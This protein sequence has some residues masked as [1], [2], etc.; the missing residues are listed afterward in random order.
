MDLRSSPVR[1]TPTPTALSSQS[2]PPASSGTIV[3]G[4][5]QSKRSLI[6]S[7][8][9][10]SAIITIIELIVMVA[11]EPLFGNDHLT[12]AFVDSGTLIL[13]CLPCIYFLLVKPMVNHLFA[14]AKVEQ[15]LREMELTNEFLRQDS[16]ARTQAEL[17]ERTKA[18][19]HIQF[20]AGLLAVVR[21]AV[22]ATGKGGVILY[23][24]LFAES[25]F[26]WTRDEVREET[27]AKITGFTAEA[28]RTGLSG[29]GSGKG[30]SGEVN[31]IRKDG[32]HFPAFMT[33]STIWRKDG[34]A[35][36]FVYTFVDVTDRKKTEAAIRASEEK[37]S[38]VVENSPI[39]IF[40]Y[41]KGLLTFGNQR[42]F[43]M[44]GRTPADLPGLTLEAIIHPDDLDMVSDLWRKRLAGIGALQ[45]YECRIIT[46]NANTRW[47]TGRTALINFDGV[48]A[49]LGN[50]Q[51]STEK[52]KAETALRESRETLHRLSARLLTAQ[53]SER[54]RVAREL[55]D[56][57]GQ[58]LSAVKFMV[59]RSLDMDAGEQQERSLRAVIPV[60]QSAVEEVR[61]ISMALR[62]STLDDLG[63]VATIAWFT[64]EFQSTYP[65]IEVERL[66][67]IEEVEVPVVLRISIFR[68]IQEAMNNAAKYSQGDK[69]MVA[70]RMILGELQVVISDN[71]V[72]FN[73]GDNRRTAGRGG[74]GLASMRERAELFGGCLV[75]TS[76]PGKGTMVTAS[77]PIVEESTS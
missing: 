25:L 74:F 64:R 53:E 51:D 26:G 45:D 35:A 65:H 13:V 52:H 14:K 18:D 48:P 28:A 34:S 38:T 30:W 72:G 44:I 68:I 70:L 27:L 59:E 19:S 16:E 9:I 1:P 29:M 10:A 32:T 62:P 73:L 77:W 17:E 21:Q 36:G 3:S 40:M 11:L 39:G 23:W 8:L 61:R 22:I 31:A 63:L 54:Q 71:G 75:L 24:N 4:L 46:P 42:F 47:I 58:S 43:Q 49:L 55:H 37:Y 6:R 66:I 67:E 57:L 50:I 20:Q 76:S 5:D 41:Q 56:S 12:M 2:I 33:S 60:L 7:L 69:V 15:D